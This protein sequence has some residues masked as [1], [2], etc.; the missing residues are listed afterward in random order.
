MPAAGAQGFAGGG[1]IARS[2]SVDVQQQGSITRDILGTQVVSSGCGDTTSSTFTTNSSRSTAC[3][4]GY[5]GRSAEL[6]MISTEAGSASAAKAAMEA[7]AKAE[8]EAEEDICRICLDT[9]KVP[10]SNAASACHGAANQLGSEDV[11]SGKVI[12]LGCK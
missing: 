1:M 11:E 6:E 8:A 9:A 4:T 3:N 7:A 10:G 12:F 5:A 2:I